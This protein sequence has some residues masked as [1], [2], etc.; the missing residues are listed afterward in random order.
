MNILKNSTAYEV[1]DG[2]IYFKENGRI[3]VV[4]IPTF[5]KLTLSSKEGYIH[6]V[7]HSFST[8]HNQK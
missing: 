1:K 8:K 5:G 2:F 7:D 3:G 6:Q 4:E